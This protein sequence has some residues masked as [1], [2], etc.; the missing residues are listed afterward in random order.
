MTVKDLKKE[1]M[2]TKRTDKERSKVLNTLVD[3]TL[4]IAIDENRESKD[5]DIITAAKKIIKMAE[6][7]IDAGMPKES[8]EYEIS[9]VQPFLPKML[10]SDE[11]KSIVAKF[12][13]ENPD[14]NKGE[15]MKYLKSID[16][17]DMK[18]ASGMI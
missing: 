17:M 13:E 3:M 16:G 8:L 11:I 7:S 4:K 1:M 15:I 5:E 14:A 18:T 10:S 6:Q 12:K 9:V 2:K